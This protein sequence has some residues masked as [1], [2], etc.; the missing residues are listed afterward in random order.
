LRRAGDDAAVQQLLWVVE[1]L[2][3]ELFAVEN[4]R[5]EAD[6]AAQRLRD[7]ADALRTQLDAVMSEVQP[8]S[9]PCTFV[10]NL[11]SKNAIAA[12]AQR[13]AAAAGAVMQEA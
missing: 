6:A 4:A 11:A 2:E 8:P 1:D 7:A 5:L 10:R 3:E 9:L 13:S 12:P